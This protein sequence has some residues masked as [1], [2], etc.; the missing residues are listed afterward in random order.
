MLKPQKRSQRKP[1]VIA[2]HAST[3][4]LASL[5]S[6]KLLYPSM[7]L[8]NHLTHLCILQSLK[9]SHLQLVCCPV[10]NAAVFGNHLEH[11]YQ[12]IRLEVD[13][14]TRLTDLN[15]A[16]APIP[17]AVRINQAIAF[18]LCQ[19][20]PTEA[21]NL[22]EVVE[23]SIPAIKQ[24]ALGRKSSLLGFLQHLAEVIILGRAVGRLVKQTIVAGYVSL[25]V[26]PK[27]GDKI[28]THNYASMFARPVAADEFNLACILLVERGVIEYEH[29][30]FKIDLVASLLPEM[31]AVSLKARKQA[32]DRIVSRSVSI[33][34]LRTGCFCAA[35]YSR[36]GNQKIDVVVFIAF[37]R[38][39]S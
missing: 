27:K 30:T 17:A 6:T 39:H 19:P 35:I 18:Q 31:K 34:W 32:I 14:P 13:H 9:L 1:Y 8:L 37:W 24:D 26:S 23:T 2:L 11:S 12:P 22:L 15:L 20:V 7:V 29:A 10:F 21:A 16:Q 5:H 3:P 25:A 4:R 33:V 36:S 28:Y 38:I